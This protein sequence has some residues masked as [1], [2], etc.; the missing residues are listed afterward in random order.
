M[1][2]ALATI[3]NDRTKRRGSNWGISPDLER[4]RAAREPKPQKPVAAIK[5]APVIVQ[6]VAP[7]SI[8]ITG[9]VLAIFTDYDGLHKA[10]AARTAALQ[11]TRE[12]LDHLSGNQPGYSGKLLAPSQYRKFG[13]VS[14]G[15]TVGALGCFLLLL[16]DETETQK[17]LSSPPVPKA[18]GHNHGGSIADVG[19]KL[20][21]IGCTLA[22]IEDPRATEKL[23]ARAKK[24]R[25]PLRQFK[26]LPAPTACA[27]DG[28]YPA[29][30]EADPNN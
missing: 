27:V 23:M 19:E 3:P 28:E 12:E 16:E 29:R 5:P 17:L 14:L 9:R 4:S 1:S 11:L 6:A 24:R 25:L 18:S 10:I 21:A 7:P 13:K 20:G 15:N 26:L 8:E 2:D 30:I 22:L